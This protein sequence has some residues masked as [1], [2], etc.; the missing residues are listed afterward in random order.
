M[1]CMRYGLDRFETRIHFCV[2]VGAINVQC[3]SGVVTGKQNPKAAFLTGSGRQRSVEDF[4][5]SSVTPEQV[6]SFTS[7]YGPLHGYID[8]NPT[9]FRFT[10]EDWRIAQVAMTDF[11]ESP[12]GTQSKPVNFEVKPG[13]RFFYLGSELYYVCTS[14]FRFVELQTIACPA[15]RRGICARPGCSQKFVRTDLKEKYCSGR[16][17]ALA[18]CESKLRHWNRNKRTYLAERKAK[19]SKQSKRRSSN[20]THKTR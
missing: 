11:W 7:R 3:S 20:G 12:W 2:L 6:V 8:S 14:I 19:R 5:N 9:A 16:C 1:Q 17:S 4:L 15:E 10:L 13:E 18:R